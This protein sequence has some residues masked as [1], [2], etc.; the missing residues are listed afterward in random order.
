[1]QENLRFKGF[2]LNI[3]TAKVKYPTGYKAKVEYI[4]HPGSV[5]IIP[6][7]DKDRIILLRQFRPVIGKFVWEIPAGTLEKREIPYSCARREIKEETGY[8]ARYIK[9]IGVIYLACGYSTEKMTIYKATGLS[10]LGKNSPEKDKDELIICKAISV[11]K[12]KEMALSGKI[13]DS[14][15]LAALALSK[16]I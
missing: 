9:K 5:G 15:T 8:K 16:L 14:K 7:L 11:A 2:F 12:V 13:E 6:F 3:Y 10:T 4:K 1:M